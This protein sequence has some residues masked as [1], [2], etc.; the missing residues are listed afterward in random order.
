MANGANRPFNGATGSSNKL[1]R[2][3]TKNKPWR[4]RIKVERRRFFRYLCLRSR[5]SSSRRTRF[6]RPA[7]RRHQ[8]PSDAAGTRGSHR[9]ETETRRGC[10]GGA[11]SIGAVTTSGNN[12][13]RSKA[14]GNHVNLLPVLGHHIPPPPPLRGSCHWLFVVVKNQEKVAAGFSATPE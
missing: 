10:G 13:P 3:F 12:F 2:M 1:T 4:G 8:R 9:V 11:E 7:V 6:T 14:C 5:S